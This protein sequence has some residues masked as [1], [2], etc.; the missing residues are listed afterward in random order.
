MDMQK[1][2]VWVTVILKPIAEKLPTIPEL[3]RELQKFIATADEIFFPVAAGD[4]SKALSDARVLIDGYVFVHTP[5]SGIHTYETPES[6]F[7]EGIL[8][9]DGAPCVIPDSEIAQIKSQVETL[10]HRG[11]SEGTRVKVVDG[12][13]KSLFGVI[14]SI[15][16]EKKSAQVEISLTSKTFLAL[17]SL[18]FLEEETQPPV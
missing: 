15:D 13:Y 8:L 9:Q 3:T 6:P 1:A 10:H 18:A 4:R 17:V 2:P 14:K 12:T 5:L 16:V 11:L 7:F